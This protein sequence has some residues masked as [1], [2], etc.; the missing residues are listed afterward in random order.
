MAPGRTFCIKVGHSAG[1]AELTN[2][3]SAPAPAFFKPAGVE[4]GRNPGTLQH[5]RPFLDYCAEVARHDRRGVI[6]GERRPSLL[7]IWCSAGARPLIVGRYPAD[8][9]AEALG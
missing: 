8:Q 6:A 1:R 7:R 4:I 3:G 9:L 2:Q 5:P